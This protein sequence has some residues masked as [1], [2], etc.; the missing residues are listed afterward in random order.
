[1]KHPTVTKAVV[2]ASFP[3]Y[4]ALLYPNENASPNARILSEPESIAEK[5]GARYV[6]AHTI[7]VCSAPIKPA[8]KLHDTK[9]TL[10]YFS[11]NKETGWICY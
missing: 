6:L 4:S 10:F 11:K 9:N 7:N 5:I 3:S 8:N 1:M 2:N